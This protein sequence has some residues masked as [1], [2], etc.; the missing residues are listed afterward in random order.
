MVEQV[1]TTDFMN[2]IYENF[3]VYGPYKSSKDNRLRIILVNN[4]TKEKQTISFPKYLIEVKLNRYLAE[5]ETVHHLDGNPLNN[6]LSNLIILDRVEHCKLDAVRRL[7][8][9]LV[10]QW[11]QKEFVVKG[12]F[13]RNRNRKDRPQQVNS[14]CSKSCTGKYG[15]YVQTT[16]KKLD[17]V[18]IKER[19]TRNSMTG[20]LNIGE[21]LTFK[22][23][24]NTEV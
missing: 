14:F 8:E 7:D 11:C 10:C 13:L 21:T 22:D 23:D 19:Y 4:I 17:K 18:H 12:A 6:D 16:N 9:T 24:G 15:K 5:N 20:E 2:K 1:D 3:K